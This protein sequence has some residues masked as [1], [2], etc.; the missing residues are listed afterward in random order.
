MVMDALQGCMFTMLYYRLWIVL[1]KPRPLLHIAQR[2][3]HL[4][5]RNLKA[6]LTKSTSTY[7]WSD[8]AA[9][10]VPVPLPSVFLPCGTLPSFFFSGVAM[11][12]TT[13]SGSTQSSSSSTLNY[14]YRRH[15]GVGWAVFRYSSYFPY[16]HHTEWLTMV[17]SGYW[18]SDLF[19][20]NRYVL[21]LELISHWI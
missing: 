8:C 19:V 11:P 12:S 1:I 21:Q 14:M 18:K 20:V 7:C 16:L 6:F 2:T 5:V 15:A 3:D 13:R 9:A 17:D 4:E 10:L